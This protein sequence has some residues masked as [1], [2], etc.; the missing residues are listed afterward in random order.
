MKRR[1][2]SHAVVG[3]ALLLWVAGR[4][5]A[6][7][8]FWSEGIGGVYGA[9]GASG[10]GRSLYQRG[11]FVSLGGIA[12]DSTHLYVVDRRTDSIFRIDHDGTDWRF[13]L[14]GGAPNQ[15]TSFTMGPIADSQER[16]FWS[17]DARDRIYSAAK[18]GSD[19]RLLLDMQDSLS[20]GRN[21]T[22]RDIEVHRDQLYWIDSNQGV[23]RSDLDGASAVRLVDTQFPAG[24]ET[25][26]G[27]AV[28]DAGIAWTGSR[29]ESIYWAKLDGSDA[30]TLIS[31][32]A[33]LGDREYFPRDIESD[34][35]RLY[36]ADW[37]GGEG[38]VYSATH[39]GANAALT[40]TFENRFGNRGQAA[41]LATPP[42]P[43]PIAAVLGVSAGVWTV[44]R[45]RPPPAEL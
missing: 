1:L 40:Y 19:V 14:S 8:L 24:G 17:D 43:E 26:R 2:R 31:L 44:G 34:G 10:M 22:I 37:V 21:V 23:F 20:P 30:T 16:L 3:L 39:G 15:S 18:D 35:G 11:G 38:G 25:T 4:A 29:H 41:G 5:P 32:D 12:A 13:I 36:W 27:L 42:V 28:S 9:E 6:A 7:R 33:A 45:R